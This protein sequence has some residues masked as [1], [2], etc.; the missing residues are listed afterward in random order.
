[1]WSY[2]GS[3]KYTETEL[4]E[5]YQAG[6]CRFDL[7]MYNNVTSAQSMFG[8]TNKTTCHPDIFNGFGSSA[9]VDISNFFGWSNQKEV[10]IPINWLARIRNRATKFNSS[11]KNIVYKVLREGSVS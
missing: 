9:G 4:E 8:G 5:D 11:E 6:R 1:M 3:L 2:V 7:S 10:S